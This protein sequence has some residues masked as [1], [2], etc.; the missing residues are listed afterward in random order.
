MWGFLN[1]LQHRVLEMYLKR[2]WRLDWMARGVYMH[3]E[4]SEFI[5]AIRGKGDSTP[6]SEAADVVICMMAMVAGANLNWDNIMAEVEQKVTVLETKPQYKNEERGGEV[7]RMKQVL[8]DLC[9]TLEDL[10]TSARFFSSPDSNGN[11]GPM[12]AGLCDIY[13]NALDLSKDLRAASYEQ[14]GEENVKNE[15]VR[16]AR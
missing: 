2:D 9:P 13:Q 5:E 7:N 12:P 10:V 8:I 4:V 15:P 16:V 3:L 14:N 11:P 6:E 1:A